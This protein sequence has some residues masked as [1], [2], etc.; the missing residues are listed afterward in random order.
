MGDIRCYSVRMPGTC[1]ELVQGALDGVTFHVTCPIDIYSRVSVEVEMGSAEAIEVAQGKWKARRSA[2]KTAAHLKLAPMRTRIGISSDIPV[3]KGMASSTAD[4]AGASYALAKAA[5]A[6]LSAD[7]IARIALSVEPSDGL[8]FNG[9]ALFDHRAGLMAEELGQP[10][11]MRIL[12]VD[13]GGEI[14]TLEFNKRDMSAILRCNEA[15]VRRALDLVRKGV[16]K[17]DIRLIAQ[18]ATLSAKLNQKI[19]FKPELDPMIEIGL[20]LRALGVCAAHSGTALGLLLEPDYEDTEAL[21][22]EIERRLGPGLKFY[23]A[24]L[25]GGGP[26]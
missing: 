4:V 14:D 5:G 26:L 19:L 11:P 10:P 3:G 25:T 15:G 6:N 22:A 18:G 12:V 21:R 13:P 8:M 2:E 17:G 9:I 1:G 23:R 7:E 24:K 20:K 16:K